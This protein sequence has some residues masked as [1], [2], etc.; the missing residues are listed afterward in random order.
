MKKNLLSVICFLACV[1]YVQ[2]QTLYGPTREGGNGGGT[3]IKFMPATNEL[4]VAKAFESFAANPVYAN[5]ETFS[6]A[7][8]TAT[9]NIYSSTMQLVRTVKI[10]QAEGNTISIPVDRFSPGIYFLQFINAGEI[11][12]VKFLKK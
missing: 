1:F 8:G 2:A 11:H 3:I 5:G 10:K 7:S 4:T 12:T 9:M 6:A